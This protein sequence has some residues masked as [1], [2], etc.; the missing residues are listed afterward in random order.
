MLC[1]CAKSMFEKTVEEQRYAEEML[2]EAHGRAVRAQGGAGAVAAA[3]NESGA[4]NLSYV[5][6]PNSVPK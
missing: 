4:H 5:A 2:T 3:G 6:A 1:R